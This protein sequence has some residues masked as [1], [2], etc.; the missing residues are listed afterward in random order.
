M[1]FPFPMPLIG[2]QAAGASLKVQNVFAVSTWTGTGATQA[3]SNGLNMAA[4]SMLW[5]KGRSNTDA[6]LIVDTARGFSGADL[7]YALESDSTAASAATA[8]VVHSL[9]S[10]GFTLSNSGIAPTNVSG[11]SY[12]G[13][14][15]CNCP[16][17]FQV[18][19]YSGSGDSDYGRTVSHALGLAPGFVLIKDLGTTDVWAVLARDG[20]GTKSIWVLA[21]GLTSTGAALST[22][23]TS[24][25]FAFSSTSFVPAILNNC[26]TSGHNYIGYF[27]AHDPDT[28][29]GII[30]CF[31]FTTD[32]SG[33]ASYDT[34]WSS[35]AQFVML[36]GAGTTGDWEMYDQTRTST[37]SGADAMTKANSTAAETTASRLS[38]SGSTLSFSGLT[39]S[40]LYIGMVVRKGPM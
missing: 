23:S 14:A 38:I 26:N 33:N 31:G 30:Q 19:T 22:G 28:T 29:N 8:Y 4:G 32:G 7:P 35:N 34:G 1:S 39:A 20:S 18:L 36:K 9:D 12:V 16:K 40:S 21:N 3:I 24:Y 2:K 13:W 5:M 11:H 15:F 17:F 10:T 25:E 37:F 27:F 6:N